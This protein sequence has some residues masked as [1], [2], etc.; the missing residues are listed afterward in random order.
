[1]IRAQL[2]F[3]EEGYEKLS[4][5]QRYVLKTHMPLRKAD[6]AAALC[7]YF[8]DHIRDDYANGTLDQQVEG[9]LDEMKELSIFGP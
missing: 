9:V 3:A 4:G 7:R 8:A 2:R 1:M 6:E 5:V